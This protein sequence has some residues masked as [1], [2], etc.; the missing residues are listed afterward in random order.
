MDGSVSRTKSKFVISLACSILTEETD[1][2]ALPSGTCRLPFS[3]APLLWMLKY[4][5]IRSSS[6]YTSFSCINTSCIFILQ[7]MIYAVSTGCDRNYKGISWFSVPGKKEKRDCG[8]EEYC[9]SRGL[10]CALYHLNPNCSKL[11][12]TPAPGDSALLVSAWLVCIYP[13]KSD[14]HIHN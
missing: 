12:V 2:P 6:F 13:P 9:A 8:T 10:E 4:P 3:Q 14:T 11:N 5:M 1:V 7:N